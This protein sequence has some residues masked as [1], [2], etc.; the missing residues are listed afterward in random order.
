LGADSV[1]DYNTQDFSRVGETFDCVLDAV[2]KTTYFHCRRL[3][4]T[5]GV[6]AATDLGPRNLN[7]PPMIWSGITR[8]NRVI[9][10]MPKSTKAF[11]DFLKDRLLAGEFRA[12]IDREYP[13]E[14][15]VEAY[16]YVETGQK[17]GIVVIRVRSAEV[18]YTCA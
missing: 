12:V 14:E 18:R 10:P 11:V 9:F 17:T 6:F 1:I 8:S 4:K 5:D 7:V 13:L 16:K 15:I 2:G 3:L